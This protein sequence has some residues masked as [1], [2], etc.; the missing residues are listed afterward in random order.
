MAFDPDTCE[1]DAW[2]RMHFSGTLAE[3][4]LAIIPP[5]QA[6]N[7]ADFLL[8]HWKCPA[9]S[10]ILDVPCGSG[11]VALE[12]ASRGMAVTGIDVSAALIAEARRVGNER[13]LDV[14]WVEADMLR[15]PWLGEF[16]AAL[17][18]GDSF[19]YMTDDQ[20]L[21]FLRAV[22]RALKPGGR[23]AME[24]QMVSEVL[25]TRFQDEGTSEVAGVPG[26][27]EAEFRPGDGATDRDVS[28]FQGGP[29][30]AVDRVVRDLRVFGNLRAAWPGGIRGGWP[31]RRRRQSV[32]H[33]FQQ[34]A[35]G[36][37]ENVTL[38]PATGPARYCADLASLP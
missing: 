14:G 5:R 4:W 25:F 15:M 29:R 35:S 20:N 10:A 1:A 13:G 24:M 9:G 19:G 23:W 32:P 6:A 28:T 37:H 30:R 27:S 17:C 21:E 8:H 33:R 34:P 2:W 11:R 12:L 7:D 16:D 36:R 18:W 3:L 22:H 26:E 31:V 38:V